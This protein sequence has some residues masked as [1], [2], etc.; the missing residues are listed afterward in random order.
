MRGIFDSEAFS[1]REKKNVWRKRKERRG[2]V[3]TPDFLLYATEN[4]EG[5][6]LATYGIVSGNSV[7][8]LGRFFFCK[9]KK[10][11]EG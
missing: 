7:V 9:K 8:T 3:R 6:F 2:S 4:A 10:R 1:Q 11:A 5:V